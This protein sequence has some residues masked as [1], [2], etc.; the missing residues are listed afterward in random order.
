M[1][2]GND[3]RQ[4][5]GIGLEMELR[6]RTTDTFEINTG[7]PSRFMANP[8]RL[9]GREYDYVDGLADDNGCYRKLSLPPC[10]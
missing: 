6:T 7:P 5:P 10:P 4:K 9:L 1:R 8:G 3:S 2:N